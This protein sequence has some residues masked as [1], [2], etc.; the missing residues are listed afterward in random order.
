MRFSS[1]T[2][3]LAFLLSASPLAAQ[4][5]STCGAEGFERYIGK[6]VKALKRVRKTNVRYVCS[7]CPATMDFSAERLT[8]V[9]DRSSGRITELGCN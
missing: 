1:L 3:L 8:V 7:I 4:D 2:T 9:Y 5:L 6:P